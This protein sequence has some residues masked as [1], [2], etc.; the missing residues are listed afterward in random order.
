LAIVSEF[1]IHGELAPLISG[2]WQGK[3]IMVERYSREKLHTSCQ[4]VKERERKRERRTQGK[5]HLSS[6]LPIPSR[7][8]LS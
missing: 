7:L 2:Q 4:S 5:I 8:Y 6:D 1:S 3:K